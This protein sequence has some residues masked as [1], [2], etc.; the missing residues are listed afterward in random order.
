MVQTNKKPRITSGPEYATINTAM[1]LQNPER[2]C[3]PPP[4]FINDQVHCGANMQRKN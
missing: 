3:M 1:V 4:V 2:V